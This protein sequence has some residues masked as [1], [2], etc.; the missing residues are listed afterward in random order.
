MNKEILKM[1]A[2]EFFYFQFANKT[3][4][5]IPESFEEWWDYIGKDLFQQSQAKE[6]T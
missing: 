2:I 5:S 3:E 1:V 6:K 4:L